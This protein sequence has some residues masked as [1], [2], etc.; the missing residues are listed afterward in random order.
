M[1]SLS[2]V[3]SLNVKC[4]KTSMCPFPEPAPPLQV[5]H[6]QDPLRCPCGLEV[7]PRT[8][9]SDHPPPFIILTSCRF[10]GL[11]VSP[12]NPPCPLLS[13]PLLSPPTF[14]SNIFTARRCVRRDRCCCRACV[15]PSVCL[16]VARRCC[17]ET[18]GRIELVLAR[19]FPPTRPTLR[20]KEIRLPSSIRVYSGR[21][22]CS[23][24]CY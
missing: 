22:L 7:R 13:S 2:T 3:K 5:T 17:V 1:L 24:R 21:E 11:P 9:D 6:P 10:S 14:Y 16:S 15:R 18:T 23:K 8:Q 12:Q 20:S 19:T 4:C